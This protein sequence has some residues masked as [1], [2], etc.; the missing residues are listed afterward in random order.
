MVTFSIAFLMGVLGLAVDVGWMH[1]V[2]QSEQA[3]TD[4]AAMSAVYAA[5]W[6][7]NHPT[8]SPSHKYCSTSGTCLA[9][10][11]VFTSCSSLTTAGYSAYTA[12]EYAE[13]NGFPASAI[14]V[15]EGVNSAPLSGG[16]TAVYW[17]E[18]LIE[19]KVPQL[20]SFVLGNK[21]GSVNAFTTATISASASACVTITDPNSTDF[22]GG[23]E[24]ALFATGTGA[25]LLA[26]CGIAVMSMG[27]NAISANGQGS[28]TG[29]GITDCGGEN[30]PLGSQST[31]TS[32]SGLPNNTNTNPCSVTNPNLGL[33]L[34]AVGG[35]TASAALNT[36][37][38]CGSF[39]NGEASQTTF[40]SNTNYATGK[41]GG[42]SSTTHPIV[43]N[44]GVYC[45][46]LTIQ[47]AVVQ[48]NPGVYVMNG[49][50]FTIQNSSTVTNTT[51]GGD[52]SGG[53]TFYLTAY[54][55]QSYHGFSFGDSNIVKVDLTAP[56]SG[57]SAVG[58][59]DYTGILIYQD[60]GLPA[61]SGPGQADQSTINAHGTFTLDG[62][63]YLPTT[64][65]LI[66][67]QPSEIGITGLDV[68]ALEF[69]GSSSL[70]MANGTSSNSTAG[71]VA[72][73]Q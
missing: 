66:T 33:A 59:P 64:P 54:G 41:N 19:Q 20:F 37:P 63:I 47:G 34:P 72:M 50:Q 49:G 36:G 2:K 12:C 32:G 25:S 30:T 70:T 16:A 6:Q 51:T 69:N 44:A 10:A 42:S 21:T 9:S 27:P 31:I 22:W 56:T 58:S 62:Q 57:P 11:T 28:I 1:Y 26:G 14:Q 45:G 73:T 38:A 15:A 23:G 46:G 71:T 5:K 55:G 48:F 8:A 7:Y 65:L 39:P 60:P 17:A 40:D 61:P 13:S 53:V 29:G 4:A 43:L 68:Y 52:G 18:V 24:G 3:A 35:T 67:G